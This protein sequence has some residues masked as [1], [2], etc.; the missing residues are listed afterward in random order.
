MI[1]KSLKENF[2]ITTIYTIICF[3]GIRHVGYIEEFSDDGI[4]ISNPNTLD[5]VTIFAGSIVAYFNFA[6]EFA[7]K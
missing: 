5:I 3:G 7:I 2:K 4:L 6:D 1:L